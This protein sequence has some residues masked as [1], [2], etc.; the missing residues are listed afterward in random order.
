MPVTVTQ[1]GEKGSTCSLSPRRPRERRAGVSTNPGVFRQPVCRQRLLGTLGSGAQNP[2][3]L[4][5][6][7]PLS[8]RLYQPGFEFHLRRGQRSAR[9]AW[10]EWKESSILL[11]ALDKT[12]WPML[13]LGDLP[14]C[15]GTGGRAA[16]SRFRGHS[17]GSPCGEAGWKLSRWGK[18]Y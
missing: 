4:L 16:L 10:L 5:L 7:P 8:V 11:T 2:V 17:L 9:Q 6:R 15:L 3:S 1:C 12:R 13:T 14:W 18:D